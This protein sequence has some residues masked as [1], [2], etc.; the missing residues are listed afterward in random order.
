MNNE[1]TFCKKQGWCQLWT[2]Q[3]AGRWA[4]RGQ[5]GAREGCTIPLRCLV[6]RCLVGRSWWPSRLSIP[7]NTIVGHQRTWSRSMTRRLRRCW[8]LLCLEP[9]CSCRSLGC[10]GSHTH[11]LLLYGTLEF[12]KEIEQH[13]KSKMY[14]VGEL[15]ILL[16]IDFRMKP[17]KG[18]THGPGSITSAIESG[19]STYPRSAA[20]G[21][22]SL[23]GSRRHCEKTKQEKSY[24]S[25]L[26]SL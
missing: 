3:C 17:V 2:E 20:S 1:V 10:R 19:V 11:K 7:T 24:Q 23:N 4:G 15:L 21:S 12:N 26:F 13:I 6:R 8:T 25:H 14:K 16:S 22:S 18:F 9:L 5:S